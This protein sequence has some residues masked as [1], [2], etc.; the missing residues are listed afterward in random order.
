MKLI[1]VV[2]GPVR[3]VL[4]SKMASRARPN[5]SFY[6]ENRTGELVLK[7]QIVHFL[8]TFTRSL[9]TSFSHGSYLQPH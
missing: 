1:G 9:A 6:K 4:T 7:K 3:I 8:R 2:R 5:A